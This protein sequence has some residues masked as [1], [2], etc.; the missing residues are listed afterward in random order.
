[1]I[2]FSGVPARSYALPPPTAQLVAERR[3][4]W[5]ETRSVSGSRSVVEGMAICLILG[6]TTWTQSHHLRRRRSHF[7]R[8]PP[9][10]GGHAKITESHGDGA[11][12]PVL[13]WVDL[14][15]L[16]PLTLHQPVTRWRKPRDRNVFW[17]FAVSGA[18]SRFRARCSSPCRCRSPVRR[19]DPLTSDTGGGQAMNGVRECT[20]VAKRG[21]WD[22]G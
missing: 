2:T 6:L 11:K 20:L 1:V 5:A 22:W 19:P 7:G 4:A 12:S 14:V 10:R 17:W 8:F 16:Y 15:D 9:G 18:C 3:S 13:A 21:G